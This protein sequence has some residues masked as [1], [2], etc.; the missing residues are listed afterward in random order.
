MKKQSFDGETLAARMHELESEHRLVVGEMLAPRAV[1][2][3]YEQR[4]V[5]PAEWLICGAM[6]PAEFHK[7]MAAGRRA[8]SYVQLMPSASGCAV[9]V[10]ALDLGNWRH[11]FCVPLVGIRAAAWV[12]S[13][14]RGDPL[15]L[16]L[17][18]GQ[19]DGDGLVAI[20]PL[21]SLHRERLDSLVLPLEGD[22]RERAF[23]FWSLAVQLATT[24]APASRASASLVIPDELAAH[25]GDGFWGPAHRH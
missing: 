14:R 7:E 17:G 3:M 16:W 19:V 1:K 21:E 22:P 13:L 2:E 25:V 24:G 4:G 11:H 10:A 8:T 9:L 5:A 20:A 18:D 6:P 12:E 15:A 23:E